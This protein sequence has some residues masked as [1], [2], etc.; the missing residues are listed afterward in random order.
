MD[1]A[2]DGELDIAAQRVETA[3]GPVGHGQSAAW[4]RAKRRGPGH[5]PGLRAE[6]PL[7]L[8]LLAQDAQD[9]A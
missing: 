7:A 1:Y 3:H 5:G 6:Q 9:A 4:T 8:L 2:V